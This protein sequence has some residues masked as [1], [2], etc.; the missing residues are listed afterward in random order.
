SSVRQRWT[1]PAQLSTA[2][3]D[4]VLSVVLG[5][6]ITMAILVTSAAA[7][8]GQA[9][10]VNSAADLAAQLTPILGDWSTGFIAVGFLAA[11]LSS[12][13]TAPLAAAFATSEIL[14]WADDLK[15]RKFRWVWL[16][17][18]LCG[19]VFSSL[20]FRPTHVILFAQVANGL[21][22]PVIA[23]FL[24]WIMNDPQI[25]GAYRNRRWTNILGLLVVVITCALGIKGILSAAN[26]L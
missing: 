25:M 8:D 14:G 16:F 3:W 7:F 26:L 10:E 15:G 19:I 18:L 5:G 1:D 17:V 6:V 21:L 2:R 12:S 23:I 11:G 13:V 9:R 4:T 22:L 20:G 24:L